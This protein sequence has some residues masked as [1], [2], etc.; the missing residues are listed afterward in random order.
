MAQG[1]ERKI[2]LLGV[3]VLCATVQCHRSI[4]SVLLVFPGDVD[5]LCKA[6][7]HETSISL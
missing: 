5:L 6:L 7:L 2:L 3:F 4:R 1:G